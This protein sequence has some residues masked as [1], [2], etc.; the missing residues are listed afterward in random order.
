MKLNSS[1]KKNLILFEC[2]VYDS[3]SNL[4]ILE[5]VDINTIYQNNMFIPIVDRIGLYNEYAYGDIFNLYN[6]NYLVYDIDNIT[7][8]VWSRN[9]TTSKDAIESLWRSIEVEASIDKN[10]DSYLIVNSSSSENTY[11]VHVYIGL[12]HYMDVTEYYILPLSHII[13][14]NICTGFSEILLDRQEV[15]IRVSPKFFNRHTQSKTTIIPIVEGIRNGSNT[16]S[17][18]FYSQ[19]TA[20]LETSDGLLEKSSNRNWQ[21]LARE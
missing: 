9:P 15:T 21:F 10:I 2:Q 5:C 8:T 6:N 12:T 7:G 11:H 19:P 1:K 13:R 4:R 20:P 3:V 16:W 17:H 18:T 14:N